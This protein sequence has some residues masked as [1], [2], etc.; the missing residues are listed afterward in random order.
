[1]QDDNVTKRSVIHSPPTPSAGTSTSPLLHPHAFLALFY[2]LLFLNTEG[3]TYNFGLLFILFF[4]CF[5]TVGMQVLGALLP[6]TGMWVC[7]L[8]HVCL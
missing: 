5:I 8:S 4:C 2:F 6:P 3:D 1:M 7:L